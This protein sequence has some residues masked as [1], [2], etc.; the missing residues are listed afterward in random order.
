M[1][2]QVTQPR[3]ARVRTAT[4]LLLSAFIF[5]GCAFAPKSSLRMPAF[6]LMGKDAAL[7]KKPTPKGNVE[8]A[9]PTVPTA[10]MTRGFKSGRRPHDGID[11]AAPIGTPIFA[12]HSGTVM[13]AG[14]EFSGYG[15]V[16]IIESEN[17]WISLYSHCHRIHVSEGDQI[18]L[19]E[20]I[21]T[22][23][24]TGNAR[25]AHLHFELRRGRKP[26]DPLRYFS[27]IASN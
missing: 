9:W 2:S 13:Y 6:R 12:S 25:G 8:L 4:L 3:P 11:L 22:I 7:D 18:E 16:V 15:N 20:K 5:Q 14:A 21:A 27:K 17:G 19:G 24:N 10:R 26:V 23:G 1:E